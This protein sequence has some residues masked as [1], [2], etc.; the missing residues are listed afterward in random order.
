M[1]KKKVFVSSHRRAIRGAVVN[2]H[3]RK[4]K[5]GKT[6]LVK[7]HVRGPHD[8]QDYTREIDTYPALKKKKRNYKTEYKDYQK[9]QGKKPRKKAK[10][11]EKFFGIDLPW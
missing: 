1:A 5:N 7:P 11:K 4:L 9:A 10:K 8:V 3:N 2:V 6:I